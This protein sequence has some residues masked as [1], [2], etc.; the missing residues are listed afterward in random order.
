MEA[1][2]TAQ[3]RRARSLRQGP[4]QCRSI[5]A[6]PARHPTTHPRLLQD[7]RPGGGSR[8]HDPHWAAPPSRTV[9][10]I[11][12]GQIPTVQK[13]TEP[14]RRPPDSGPPS[15]L[16]IVVPIPR[17]TPALRPFYPTGPRAQ[18]TR[19]TW[20]ESPMGKVFWLPDDALSERGAGL[21]FPTCSEV[22]RTRKWGLRGLS[23]SCP[24]C[25]PLELRVERTGCRCRENPPLPPSPGAQLFPN[26]TRPSPTQSQRPTLVSAADSSVTMNPAVFLSLPDLR[27]SLLLLVS[28]G[29][30][31]PSTVA[32]TACRRRRGGARCPHP[33]F[34]IFFSGGEERTLP[35]CLHSRHL[36]TFQAPGPRGLRTRGRGL[37]PVNRRISPGE[38]IRGESHREALPCPRIQRLFRSPG[39]WTW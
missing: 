8:R 1:Q 4:R 23:G 35:R 17:E 21:H 39:S 36:S 28:E 16:G 19:R 33:C 30:T 38:R 7:S 26:P 22:G 11:G 12:L 29:M 25:S 6:S 14:H 3:A 37:G 32:G 20:A 2:A 34:L 24:G 31:D 10:Y 13:L 18:R 5:G 27:C 15:L 9:H